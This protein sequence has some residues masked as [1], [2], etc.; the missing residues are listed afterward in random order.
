MK[1]LGAVFP[2]IQLMPTGGILPK[3]VQE[4]VRAGALCV[5]LGSNLMPSRA[6]E[7]GDIASAKSQISDALQ[8]LQLP[9]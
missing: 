8:D 5:G 7:A 3:D 1:A 9:Q 4:Y 6:L 2:E